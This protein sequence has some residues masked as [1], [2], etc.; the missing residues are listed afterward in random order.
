[1]RAFLHG[2]IPRPGRS[3]AASVLVDDWGRIAA[4]GS[5]E[6]VRA[7]LPRGAETV[8]LAGGF[9]LPAFQDAHV[10]LCQT[11][12]YLARP[13]LGKTKSLAE[14]LEVARRW[15]GEKREGALLVEGFDETAWPEGRLP[16]RGELDS[17]EPARPLVFRR[18]CGHIA[19]ANGAALSVIPEHTAGVDR[20]SGRLEEEVVF[21]LER[22]FFPPTPDENR[23][24]IL[25]ASRLAL[26]LGIT[27][28]HE[29]DS[30]PVAEAYRR[31]EAEGLLNLR[32]F[33]YA[34]ASPGEAARLRRPGEGGL[35]RAAGAKVFLDG[36]IGGRTA[37]LG[38]PYAT[39]GEG[40]LLAPPRAIGEM[41]REAGEE[42]VPI[43]FHAIGDRAIDALLDALERD[44]AAGARALPH[45]LE[46]AEMISPDGMGRARA[47]GLRLSMQPN[48][49]A[50]W[51]GAGGMYEERLGRD[52]AAR[53]NRFR[54][55]L[56]RGIPLAF[57]SDCMPLDP[58]FGLEGAVRHPVAE[59]RLSREEAHACYTETAEDFVP[60][61]G[62]GGSLAPGKRA[63]FLV[64]D[65]RSEPDGPIQK[66]DLVRTVSG[67]E[68]VHER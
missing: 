49:P 43:A 22:D 17:V 2:R 3:A 58:F 4:V 50:R 55:I 25:R 62:D 48:F 64:F 9:I 46:H 12:R 38:E 67:G 31:L 57:G 60:G 41:L 39:G 63:D 10:H 45:R 1:M 47:L 37:A 29:F 54:T 66:E 42:E 56:R 52:R 68:I 21:R 59:E 20:P 61:G 53:L 26:S 5:E 65:A 30:P 32:V 33:F 11:G 40:I 27:T 36:S 6:E 18:V 35:F 7:R 13:D 44:R 8:D 15:R 51:G 19:A 14:A 16:R 23:E 34:N 28:I 24:A